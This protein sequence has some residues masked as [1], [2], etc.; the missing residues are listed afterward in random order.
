MLAKQLIL[1]FSSTQ[2]R[3][4]SQS[5]VGSRL[6]FLG[7]QFPKR[8]FEFDSGFGFQ[9]RGGWRRWF[10]RLSAGDVVLGFIITN[11]AIFLLWRVADQ[12]FMMNNFTVSL[13]NFRSGRLHTL[14][15]SAFSHIDGEHIISNMIGLYFFGMNIG[16][17]FGPEY[18]LKLYLAGAIGGSVFYLIHH[19]LMASSSKGQGMF[20]M[21]PSRIPGLGASGAVNAIMLLDIF[22]NP[23]ATLYFDFIIPVPAILLGI[24]LIGKDMLR[25]LE[26]NTHISGSA[27]FG[28]VAVA[29]I[30]WARIRRGRF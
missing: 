22:L 18:L 29:A 20:M 12:R 11:V 1:N 16:R 28:G 6:W 23:R 21:D 14:I 24:F 17:A 2:T 15:T 27:H 5:L 3:L 30:A 26:G 9:R 4:S 25:I 13:D 8:R 7:A 19:A 10:Q